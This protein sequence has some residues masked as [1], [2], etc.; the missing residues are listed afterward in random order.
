MAKIAIIASYGES[1]IN[2]RGA[3]LSTLVQNGH[4]VLALAP[5]GREDLAMRLNSI[6]VD[7]WQINLERTGLNPVKDLIL[8]KQL[9]SL[10]RAQRPDVVIAYTIKPVIYGSIAARVTRIASIN[11]IIT[12]L[13]STF[14]GETLKGKLLGHLVQLLYRIAL[15]SN[16][17][18][19]FQNPDDFDLF[20]RRAIINKDTNVALINGSGVDLDYFSPVPLQRSPVVFLLI[21]RLLQE[22]GIIE[23]VRAARILKKRYHNIVFRLLG[24]YDNNPSALSKKQVEKWN[25]QGVI[26]FV[27]E[28]QDVR[29]YISGCSVY[30]LPSYYREGTPRTV[31]EAMAM[32]R[33]IVTTDA[34]GCRETVKEEENG[35]LV[36]VKDVN[37]LVQA[38]ERFILHPELIEK[39]GKISRRIAEEK[40]D[41]HKVNAVIMRTIGLDNEKGF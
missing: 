8:L 28:H 13:G 21:A 30:V 3:L 20:K 12:G 6:G 37:A 26:D 36:P 2:F 24:P 35:F 4:E 16:T 38:M 39:M 18:I 17:S 9:I 5:K 15:S 19:F 27:G 10:M 7:F 40:Y 25:N 14:I 22:K 1:L 31:L 33:P 34:P 29:P 23:Y 41:V 11:S 32:G